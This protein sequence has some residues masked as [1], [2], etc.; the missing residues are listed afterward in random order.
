[1]EN[2]NTP[3]AL[4]E[5]IFINGIATMQDYMKPDTKEMTDRLFAEYCEHINET[6]EKDSPL[7]YMIHGF[8]SGTLYGIDVGVKLIDHINNINSHE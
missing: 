7:Y 6:G 2:K 4:L 3:E 8:I 1:M 5:Q